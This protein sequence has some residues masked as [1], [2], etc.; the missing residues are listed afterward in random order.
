MAALPAA[1]AI[2]APVDA[3]TSSQRLHP[4]IAEYIGGKV[5]P[6]RKMKVIS[7]SL[8]DDR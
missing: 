6:Q 1:L 2:P 7:G 3:M 8:R 4:I 5:A